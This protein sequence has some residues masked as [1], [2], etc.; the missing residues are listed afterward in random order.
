MDD[1]LDCTTSSEILGK[2]AGKD[3]N[4]HKATYVR[5]LGLERS[6]TEA[7]RLIE[8]AKALLDRYGDKAIPLQA[9]ADY[10]VSRK[11]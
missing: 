8:E 5:L 11:N 6:K 10:I 7:Q 4:T 2:T 9:I 3:E 1:I